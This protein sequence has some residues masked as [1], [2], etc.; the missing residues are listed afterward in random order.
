MSVVVDAERELLDEIRR[1][2]AEVAAPVADEVDRDSR[3]PVEALDALR[4]TGA[5]SAAVPEALGGAGVSLEAIA[6][7]C[8]ELAR[9]CSATAMV[10]AMHQIQVLTIARHLDGAAWFEGYLRDLHREQRLIAS[11]TSEVGT[12]GDMGRSIAAV[13]P[14]EGGELEFEKQAPTVSYGAHAD[15]LL[16]TLRRAPDAEPGDQV[17][18]LTRSDQV[19]LEPAGSWDTL[20]MRGTCSPGFVVRARFAP[21]QVLAT[22]FAEVMNQSM[23]PLSH[24]LWSHVWL[25]IATEAFERARAFVRASARQKPGEPP[26]AARRLSQVMAELSLLRGE[27]SQALADFVAADDDGGRERL[28]TMASVL[29]FNNLKLAASEQAPRVCGGA[30]EAIGIVGYKNDT[31]YSVGRHLR[32]ALSARLMVANE[33]LL[34]TDAGLLLIAK[35]A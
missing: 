18:A 20:G 29:R 12:G 25:G 2:A 26:Q 1:I 34:A 30:L 33:R 24:I 6:R 11:V 31:P 7:C 13:T 23:V 32:D 5:L 16:T 4:S 19:T 10:F 8:Y 14:C 15:D 22:P 17:M 28:M 21:E 35:E 27:V 3:F 9:G